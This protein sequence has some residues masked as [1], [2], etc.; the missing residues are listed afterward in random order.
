MAIVSLPISSDWQN[1]LKNW[2]RVLEKTLN[3][4]VNANTTINASRVNVTDSANYFSGGTAETVLAE[5]GSRWVL[6]TTGLPAASSS[7]TRKLVYV[8]NASLTADKVYICFKTSDDTYSWQA[9]V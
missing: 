1:T 4:G 5:L 2:K 7:Y 6:T 9:L 8:S 3:G